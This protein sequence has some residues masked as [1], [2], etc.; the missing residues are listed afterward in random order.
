MDKTVNPDQPAPEAD[1][2]P[3]TRIGD[4]EEINRVGFG[5]WGE[6]VTQRQRITGA[7]SSHGLRVFLA[8]PGTK[9]PWTKM[10]DA[11]TRVS[12]GRVQWVK[13]V[14][15]WEWREVTAHDLPGIKVSVHQAETP[16]G[17]LTLTVTALEYKDGAR[18]RTL[19]TLSLGLLK[20][21]QRLVAIS[22]E[23]AELLEEMRAFAL[24]AG[25]RWDIPHD[26]LLLVAEALAAIHAGEVV[27]APIEEMPAA[28]IAHG[29]E[30]LRGLH[31]DPDTNATRSPRAVRDHLFDL[32]KCA[33]LVLE[34]E[35]WGKLIE[36]DEGDV[37]RYIAKLQE[38]QD[39]ISRAKALAEER[40]ARKA[41]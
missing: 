30:A 22:M 37:D 40:E 31:M 39:R 25:D 5:A 6:L 27:G 41:S 38:E 16:L 35:D 29:V 34:R 17:T 4:W 32:A 21:E 24:T 2:H 8:K 11:I 15:A 26:S 19:P 28:S 9:A 20:R 12:A 13:H 14:E 33:G 23:A 1:V 36:H 3:V 10:S 18:R 7:I